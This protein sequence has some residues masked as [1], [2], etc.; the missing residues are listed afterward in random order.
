MRKNNTDTWLLLLSFL[1]F[2]GFANY[3]EENNRR[4]EAEKKLDDEKRVNEKLLKAMEGIKELPAEIKS[5]LFRLR[6]DFESTDSEIS[7]CLDQ[8]T[9]LMS[10]G[11]IE[12][13]VFKLA[14]IIEDTLRER[15]VADGD[16][17]SRSECPGFQKLLNLAYKKDWIDEHEQ[18]FGQF[19]RSL[20]NT[21]AHDVRATFRE[22][23]ILIAF[24]SGI[25]V[26]YQLKGVKRK[27][28]AE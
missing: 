4:T 19:V 23:Q 2:I 5:Q 7:S 25:E 3:S 18:S 16:Y 21:K 8:V 17:N 14:G 13:A 10:I 24:L 1:V 22:N 9:E 11:L 20:R 15:F 6:V 12:D 28:L 27:E 26:F